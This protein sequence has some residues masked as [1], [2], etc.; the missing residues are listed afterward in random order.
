LDFPENF[1]FDN[2]TNNWIKISYKEA[3]CVNY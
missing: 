2:P 1:K 3:I